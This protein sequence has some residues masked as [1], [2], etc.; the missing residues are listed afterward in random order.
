MTYYLAVC[1]AYEYAD[2]HD[3]FAVA[4]RTHI[5]EASTRRRAQKHS[6]KV[7]ETDRCSLRQAVQKHA[8]LKREAQRQSK[9]KSESM[10]MW[11]ICRKRKK[12]IKGEFI[13]A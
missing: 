11:V 13:S 12:T 9:T 10:I 3:A 8:A 6:T 5:A 4:V 7:N 1:S 2:T